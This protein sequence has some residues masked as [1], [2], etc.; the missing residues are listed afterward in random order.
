[1]RRRDP[2]LRRV[3]VDGVEHR[4]RPDEDVAEHR[5]DQPHDEDVADLHAGAEPRRRRQRLDHRLPHQ[6]A[7]REEA[8][9]LERVH[10]VVV[11]RRVVEE[12]DV[13]DVEVDA[14]RA[15]ARRAGARA[16]AAARRRGA[17]A[18]GRSIGPV[19]PA[20]KQSGARSPRITCC[21]MC[22]KKKCSSPSAS[23][24]ELSASTTS[25]IPVQKHDCRQPGTG[26]P[27]P[28]RACACGAGR[29]P[30]PAPS[31]RAGAARSSR[32]REA[33]ASRTHLED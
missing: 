2:P 4:V 26:W 25:A 21:I 23:I 10:R 3:P 7:A 27:A 17:R 33:T 18:P 16:R 14:P 24:G 5:L 1:M 9:V 22:R 12:R 19:S 20:T 30:R 28:A 29:G 8:E 32:G 15:A 11:Q 31:G 6:A 13:P